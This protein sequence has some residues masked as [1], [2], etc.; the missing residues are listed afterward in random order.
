MKKI[1]LIAEAGVNH[2]GDLN[3]ALQLIDVAATAGADFVK[4]QTF[5]TE[6]LSTKSAQKA[7]YQKRLTGASESQFEMLK[8]LEL[9]PAAHKILIQHC[10]K[11]RIRFLSAPFDSDSL[12]LL[13]DR[14]GL[15]LIKI[16]SGELTNAPFLLEIARKDKS[17]LL[18]TGMSTLKEVRE[19]LS[20][21]AFGFIDEAQKNKKRI[22]P[23]QKTFRQ[24]FASKPG[25]S[26]LKAK[27][28]LLHCTTEYPCP[29]EDVNLHAMDTL[30]REFGLPVGYS[31][32]TPGITIPIAA[33]AR[34]AV[35][36]EKHFTLDKTLPGPDHP[37]SIDPDEL[38]ALVKA[39][40]AVESAVGDGKKRPS[41]SELKNI[42]IARKSLVTGR[43]IKKGEKFSIENL[44]TK[45]PGSGMS[46][47]RYWELLGKK[48]HR[49]YGSDELII[50]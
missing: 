44:T 45:R 37:A 50:E 31:D 34:G 16:P 5:K 48:A 39:V 32:H 49:D 6:N 35:V 7:S 24:A 40:R 36:I 9:S 2:N 13:T 38:I 47:I 14:Y 46:P 22:Q 1:I 42:P 11:K 21:L 3:R 17:V 23:G 33:A 10:R 28:T 29:F 15:P 20:V 26:A 12:N 30:A 4:F 41:P 19:A 18:S 25:Q 43:P 27:V 8:K